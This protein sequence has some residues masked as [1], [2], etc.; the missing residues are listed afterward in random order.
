MN[1]PG[2][3][4]LA[5]VLQ[6]AFS[7]AAEGKGAERHANGQPFHEQRMQTISTLLGSDAGMA[8]QVCKKV[9]EGMALPHAARER[10]LLGAI[11]YIAGMVIF[12][13]QREEARVDHA[14][15]TAGHVMTDSRRAV[16]Q[17]LAGASIDSGPMWIEWHGGNQPVLD[18]VIVE[19]RLR[20]GSTHV[21][22]AHDLRWNHNGME[23][24][25]VAWREPWPEDQQRVDLEP[26]VLA[27]VEAFNA[28]S[29]ELWTEDDERRMDVVA[30]NGNDG[31]AYAGKGPCLG[32]GG[33]HPLHRCG[34]GHPTGED[35][36]L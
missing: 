34:R 7:Q 13:R 3:E 17:F 14:L 6:A 4:Q 27:N 11:V 20:D 2:Y 16:E 15:L 24:D 1:A 18:G 36:S 12:H 5:E 21:E 23:D 22:P 28:G 29:V 26:A 19:V 35:E 31:A 10:E 8:F 32:C 9:T 30:Q 25:I 33:P